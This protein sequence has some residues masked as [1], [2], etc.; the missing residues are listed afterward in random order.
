MVLTFAAEGEA[1]GGLRE[2]DPG[3]DLGTVAG[4]I[5]QGFAGDLDSRAQAAL[6]E[7]RWMARLWPLFGWLAEADPIL[8]ESLSGFVWEEPVPGKRGLQIVANVSLNPAPGACGR[9]VICNVVTRPEY[10]RQGIARQLTQAAV[11]AA[12][13]Q[14]AESVVLQVYASN[15]AALRLYR[16][17]GF[18]HVAGET[19]LRRQTADVVPLADA[20][21]YNLRR[22]RRSDGGAALSLARQVTPEALQW[23]VPVRHGDYQADAWSSAER[24]LADWLAGRRVHRLVAW[25][26]ERLSGLL[27]LRA[28][29]RGAAHTLSLL[30]HPEDRGRVEGALLSRALGLLA[31]L[32]PRPVWATVFEDH[33]EAVKVLREQGFEERRTLLVMT[34]DLRR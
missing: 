31:G 14:G 6:R 5:A 30:V 12:R 11:A 23:L 15:M 26:G 34:K 33:G 20:P 17:L 29:R 8:R 10:R 9:A 18:Q 2:V 21:G 27:T 32:S 25:K 22:W 13:E 28:V 4:L 19:D 24:R 1:R 3:R 16:E 7:M